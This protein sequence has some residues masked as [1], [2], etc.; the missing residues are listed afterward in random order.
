MADGGEMQGVKNEKVTFSP[1]WI[2]PVY[3]LHIG[4]FSRGTPQEML[5]LEA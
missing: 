5:S 3:F 1:D 4:I 2:C